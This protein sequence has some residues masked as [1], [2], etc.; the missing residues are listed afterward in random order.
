[1]PTDVN[2]KVRVWKVYFG[3]FAFPVENDKYEDIWWKKA[4]VGDGWIG[5][6]FV[7]DFSWRPGHG[8]R[9]AGKAYIAYNLPS[10]QDLNVK[11]VTILQNGSVQ[12]LFDDNSTR[13]LSFEDFE[14]FGNVSSETVSFKHLFGNLYIVRRG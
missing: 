4:P 10:A 13:I 11:N 14:G 1:M 2:V 9:N 5:A 3:I 8:W 12:I 6:F 7:W